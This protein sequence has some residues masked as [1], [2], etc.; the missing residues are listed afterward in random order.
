MAI[1]DPQILIPLRISLL[2]VLAESKARGE[3]N[4]VAQ[5]VVPDGDE[6]EDAREDLGPRGGGGGGVEFGETRFACVVYYNY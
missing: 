6:V 3:L 5:G 4:K 1:H 2:P